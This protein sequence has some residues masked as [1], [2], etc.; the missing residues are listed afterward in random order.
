MTLKRAKQKKLTREQKRNIKRWID[1]LRSGDYNQG[2]G[3]LHLEEDEYGDKA[4]E[5]YC[6]LGVLCKVKGVDP[7]DRIERVVDGVRVEV[8]DGSMIH[9]GLLNEWTGLEV[10]SYPFVSEGRAT[11]TGN[12]DDGSLTSHLAMINDDGKSFKQIA[13]TI[14]RR[15]DAISPGWKNELR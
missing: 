10:D 5:S 8:T 11:I 12:S 6:C 14:E 13:N 15:A 2:Q 3:Q 1:A 9:A 7:D 4:P